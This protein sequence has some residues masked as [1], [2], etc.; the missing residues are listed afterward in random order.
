MKHSPFI[1]P[2]GDSEVAFEEAAIS[3][4]FLQSK[5]V[6]MPY[7][8]GLSD[9]PLTAMSCSLQPRIDAAAKPALKIDLQFRNLPSPDLV[10]L[11]GQAVPRRS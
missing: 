8:E 5:H 7:Y 10:P 2:E 11:L 9:V 1:N 3:I 4:T 6:A